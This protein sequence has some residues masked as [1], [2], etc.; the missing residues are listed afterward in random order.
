MEKQ[1]IDIEPYQEKDI[2]TKLQTSQVPCCCRCER[3]TKEKL[4]QGKKLQFKKKSSRR[5]TTARKF[6]QLKEAKD[7][8]H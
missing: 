3:P 1:R 2:P 4:Q 6:L 7:N 8:C 5:R